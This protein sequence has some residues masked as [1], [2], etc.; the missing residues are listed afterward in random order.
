MLK[1]SVAARAGGNKGLADMMIPGYK[2]RIWKSISAEN[3]R[4]IIDWQNKQFEKSIEQHKSF[5]SYFLKYKDIE[6][7]FAPSQKYRKPAVDWRRQLA[8]G[9]LHF[10]KF[11]EGPYGT[12]YRPGKTFDRLRQAIPFSEHEWA[13]RKQYR[14]WDALTV[15]F[16]IWGLFLAHR[17]TQNY[18]VVWC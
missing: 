14:S 16:T 8:R 4:R 10:G 11:F 9:T 1:S 2:D 15:G 5:Q 7:K 6:A 18:P 17:A 12:D 3:Q 13:E